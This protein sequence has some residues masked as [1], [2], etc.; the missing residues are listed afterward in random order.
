M[1]SLKPEVFFV[2]LLQPPL[3][4]YEIDSL[5]FVSVAAVVE[6]VVIVAP[7]AVEEVAVATISAALVSLPQVSV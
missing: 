4:S 7:V 5:P 6:T 1:K 3:V 2:F